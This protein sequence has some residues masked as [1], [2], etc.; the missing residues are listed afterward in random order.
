MHFLTKKWQLWQP[1]C[2]WATAV[3]MAAVAI[4]R[5]AYGLARLVLLKEPQPAVDLLQ[6]YNEV[7]LWFAGGNVY[8]EL[9]KGGVY[10][11]ASHTILRPFLDY[12]SWPFARYLWALT[13]LVA[14]AGLIYMLVRVSDAEGIGQK[15]YVAL[16]GLTTYA[17]NITIG[18]GQLNIHAIA[19]SI[20][21]FLLIDRCADTRDWWKL[22]IPAGI[23]IAVSLVKPT[24]T[25]PF[26]LVALFVRGGW[27]AAIGAGVTYTAFT[28][29]ATAFQD[30]GIISL[31][32]AWLKR[33]LV[34]TT[35]GT[36]AFYRENSAAEGA[37]AG[38]TGTAGLL[39]FDWVN[40]QLQGG[41]GDIHNLLGSLGRSE[42]NLEASLLI[43]GIFA[44]WLYFHRD[45]ELYILV[46]IAALVSRFWA[47]HRVY[48]D[49]LIVLPM[50]SLFRLSRQHQLPVRLRALA[51]LLLALGTFSILVPDRV[52]FISPL[53]HALFTNG[54]TLLWLLMLSLLISV[55][56]VQ[57]NQ[58][59]RPEG[60]QL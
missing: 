8:T 18:N 12:A 15:L 36:S 35:I 57:R 22:S 50:V 60:L 45:S 55:A 28:L 54:H 21:G 46:G 53:W 13:T 19:A 23:L 11:P 56:S 48:D 2:F 42:F 5:L 59:D 29:F 49:L 58:K 24:L 43:L 10:P 6:R 4:P 41:Y 17:T 39:D 34:G 3:V 9:Y 27:L 20:A 31:H 40:T 30:T 37:A 51:G 25:A 38:P 33:G 1:V 32:R 16:I 47:Y 26:F 52:R 44:V 7:R 14:L